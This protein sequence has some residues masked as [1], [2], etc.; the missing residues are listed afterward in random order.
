MKEEEGMFIP[1]DDL[2]NLIL[3]TQKAYV[4]DEEGEIVKSAEEYGEAVAKELKKTFKDVL[5]A[6]IISIE[7]MKV[8]EIGSYAAESLKKYLGHSFTDRFYDLVDYKL[9]FQSRNFVFI[10]ENRK[11]EFEAKAMFHMRFG[12]TDKVYNKLARE[13][14][15]R[16]KKDKD[17]IGL[18]F[19]VIDGK[20]Y[21]NVNDDYEEVTKSLD[22]MLDSLDV[23]KA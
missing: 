15:Q 7:D 4:G 12:Y 10:E 8:E 9:E 13:W 22:L 2:I 20:L 5:P 16:V 11:L 17:W 3:K 6:G 19:N 23:L 1:S 21:V 14:Y 18:Q